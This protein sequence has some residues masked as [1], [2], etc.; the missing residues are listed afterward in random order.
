ML[1]WLRELKEKIHEMAAKENDARKLA[2]PTKKNNR[3]T[4]NAHR[5][6]FGQNYRWEIVTRETSSENQFSR[7]LLHVKAIGKQACS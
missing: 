1:G 4:Y 5:P 3:S 2:V 7:R 6:F